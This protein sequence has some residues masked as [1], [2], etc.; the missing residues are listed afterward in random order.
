MKLQ[1][2][3]PVQL[4]EDNQ[5]DYDSNIVLFGSCF[6]ENLSKKFNFFKFKNSQ[7][8]FGINFHPVAIERVINHVINK[9]AYNDED[10]FFL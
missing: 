3:I 4:T 6:A 9:K 2:I 10:V 5:I 7:N 8:P 1:T